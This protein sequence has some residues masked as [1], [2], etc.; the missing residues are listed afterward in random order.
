MLEL[1]KKEKEPIYYPVLHEPHNGAG[2]SSAPFNIRLFLREIIIILV[3][4]FFFLDL[5]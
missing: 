5:T 3:F 4:L 2:F 1:K